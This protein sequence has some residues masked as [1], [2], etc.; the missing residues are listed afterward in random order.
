MRDRGIY[1]RD[2]RLSRLGNVVSAY[3]AEGGHRERSHSSLCAELWPQVVGQWYSER[4]RVIRLRGK[5]LSVCCD[6]PSLA[7]QL[8]L[9]QA[10]V[11]SRLNE[12]LGGEIITSLRTA[13]VGPRRERHRLAEEAPAEGP[14]TD[15]LERIV[16]SEEELTA[17]IQ[18]AAAIPDKALR[19]TFQQL[20]ADDCRL[21]HW[22]QAR[23][24]RPCTAC[25]AVH[26][27][28]GPRCFTCVLL[29]QPAP[30]PGRT[31]TDYPAPNSRQT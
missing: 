19:E 5:E 4:T 26:N 3:L 22:R 17:C 18:R 20:L 14:A 16:L 15:E 23:G 21:R 10:T 13:S 2:G 29:S 25:G 31:G 1:A 27:E 7:Q 24:Y 30:S 6:S 28:P 8:Q 12:R 11:I 9:D